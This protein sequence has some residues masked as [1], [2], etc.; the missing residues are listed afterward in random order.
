MAD[1]QEVDDF[2]AHHGVLGMKWGRHKTESASGTRATTASKPSR[3]VRI[4][5]RDR[6][7]IGA[8]VRNRERARKLDAKA[9]RTYTE[10]TIKGQKAAE[11]IFTNYAAK[12]INHPDNKT[13]SKMTHGEKVATGWIYGAMGG[14]FLGSIAA[15][16]Y[17]GS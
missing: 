1:Q 11:K 14:L 13:A 6:E 4:A 12:V 5:A 10:T 3:Q 7:I 2:L 17:A 9:A 8:R 16:M 15:S